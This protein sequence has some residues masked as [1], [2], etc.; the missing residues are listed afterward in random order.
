MKI[1]GFKGAFVV[2]AVATAGLSGCATTMDNVSEGASKFWTTVKTDLGMGDKTPTRKAPGVWSNGLVTADVS[3]KGVCFVTGPQGVASLDTNNGVVSLMTSKPA[4]GGQFSPTA[5]VA[6]D[7][8]VYVFQPNG[9]FKELPITSETAKA[10]DRFQK[11]AV[12]TAKLCETTRKL[13]SQFTVA[14]PDPQQKVTVNGGEVNNRQPKKP[15]APKG[16]PAT[17]PAASPK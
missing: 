15:V 3:K 11:Q 14:N 9:K 10:I 13:E 16:K 4:P 1:D 5:N 7:G 6:A 8:V 2:A 17:K 12:S